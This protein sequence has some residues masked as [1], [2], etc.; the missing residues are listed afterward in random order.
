MAENVGPVV[1]KLKLNVS[2]ENVRLGADGIK[3]LQ[4]WIF[5]V[6]R[7]SR[8][9]LFCRFGVIYVRP[10][11]KFLIGDSLGRAPVFSLS[12]CVSGRQAAFA[13]LLDHPS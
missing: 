12:A 13:A 9:S 6:Y 11:W 10:S 4:V 5:Q 3:A 1:L 8:Y 7:A 2:Y